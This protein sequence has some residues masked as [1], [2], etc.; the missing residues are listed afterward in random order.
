MA[1]KTNRKSDNQYSLAS[2]AKSCDFMLGDKGRDIVEGEMESC[3][4]PIEAEL[5]SLMGKHPNINTI[6]D[7]SLV[8]A[9]VGTKVI[10]DIVQCHMPEASMPRL[11]DEVLVLEPF[12]AGGEH[13]QVLPLYPC[14][15][16]S[17]RLCCI[18]YAELQVIRDALELP[19]DDVIKIVLVAGLTH[20][21]EWI[22]KARRD[23]FRRE[24]RR[25]HDW[26]VLRLQS[27]MAE[28]VGIH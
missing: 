23:I 11:P 3:P 21:K 16:L 17:Y 10:L 12:L 8:V 7:A 5:R 1:N 28:G 15:K 19:L 2:M 4:A 6:A 24:L 26:A 18:C 14:C 22:P 25:F 20:A 27:P 13:F 9:E